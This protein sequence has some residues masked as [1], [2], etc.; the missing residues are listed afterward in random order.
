MDKAV[1]KRHLAEA[2]A[3]AALGESTIARQR[4]L[5]AKLESDGRD[6]DAARDLLAKLEKAQVMHLADRDRI[7][8]ELVAI[9]P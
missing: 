1:L 6:S 3:H 7:R 2:V 8:K 9:G 4:R 5:V